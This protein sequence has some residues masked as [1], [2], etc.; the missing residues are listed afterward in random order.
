MS[1]LSRQAVPQSKGRQANNKSAGY[2]ILT[3]AAK[4]GG[5]QKGDRDVYATENVWLLAYQ[6]RCK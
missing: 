6:K 3:E 1:A 5:N 2:R 4:K